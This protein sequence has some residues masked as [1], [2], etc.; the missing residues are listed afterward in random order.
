MRYRTRSSR[1]D[2]ATQ[3]SLHTAEFH[4]RVHADFLFGIMG[5]EFD[6]KHEFVLVA[7]D[8]GIQD[9]EHAPAPASGT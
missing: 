3:M 2:V 4:E 8:D 7:D 5:N 6:R 1:A 9:V